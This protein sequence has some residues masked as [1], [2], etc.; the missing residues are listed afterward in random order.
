MK[1]GLDFRGQGCI[2][3]AITTAKTI[4]IAVTVTITIIIV[5]SL[6]WSIIGV[7]IELMMDPSCLVTGPEFISTVISTPPC[8]LAAVY[9]GK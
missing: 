8:S 9:S 1:K 6:L 5:R 2:I 4:T 7:L 3:P